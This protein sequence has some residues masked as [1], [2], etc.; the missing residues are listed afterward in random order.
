MAAT[1]RCQYAWFC[2]KH[3][4]SD[5]YNNIF[6]LY[7]TKYKNS[8][9]KKKGWAFVRKSSPSFCQDTPDKESRC[10]WEVIMIVLTDGKSPETPINTGVPRGEE[11][12]WNWRIIVTYY[13][14]LQIRK[15]KVEHF[16][17]ADYKSAG[18]PNG[19]QPPHALQ[20]RR[21]CNPSYKKVRPMKPG[22]L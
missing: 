21:I 9:F 7:I 2:N 10:H 22:D 13:S 20:F 6:Y 8:C 5:K 19:R 15:E 17:T 14:G 4:I 11:C 3:K 1:R 16:L 12:F 18:T